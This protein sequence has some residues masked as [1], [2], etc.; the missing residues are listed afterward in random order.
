[1]PH[2][3]S[4]ETNIATS[5]G[6]LQVIIK[7]FLLIKIDCLED[8]NRIRADEEAHRGS[9]EV[10]GPFFAIFARILFWRKTIFLKTYNIR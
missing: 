5:S 10:E 1:M 4:L 2:G 6:I 8:L 7:S 9:E 3:S